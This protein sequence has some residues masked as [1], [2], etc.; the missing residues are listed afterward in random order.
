MLPKPTNDPTDTNYPSAYEQALDRLSCA[1]QGR[2]VLQLAFAYIPGM[3]ASHA[4]LM[5]IAAMGEGGA[6][7]MHELGKVVKCVKESI[8]LFRFD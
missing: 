4:G 2:P 1:F 8:I 3:L 5:A 6:R 7:V